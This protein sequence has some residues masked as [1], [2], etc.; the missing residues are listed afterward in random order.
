M[1]HIQVS[2]TINQITIKSSQVIP[3]KQSNTSRQ[4]NTNAKQ[5]LT[6]KQPTSNNEPNKINK[7]KQPNNSKYQITYITISKPH[8]IQRL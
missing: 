4:I 6:T 5:S 7:Y 8:Y 3:L 1:Y 2:N